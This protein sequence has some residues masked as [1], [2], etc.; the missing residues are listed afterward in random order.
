[1]IIDAHAHA[2]PRLGGPSGGEPA[3]TH[4]D[5]IQH[6]VQ[7]HVQGFRRTR[8]G[9][10]LD[11]S[12]M[13]PTGDAM[14]DMPS[15]NL[16]ATTYGRIEVTAGGEDYF[17]QWYP[18]SMQ[19]MT[20]PPELMLAHMDY[21]GVDM[22]VLQ[23]DHVYG[24]LN[25]YLA[26]C[27]RRYPS[28]FIGLAQIKEWQADQP[29]QLKRLEHAIQVLGLRGLYFAVEAFAVTGFTDHLDDAKF[30]P[31]WNLV[32]ELRIPVFW[33]LYTSQRD[34]LG[35]YLEQ[36]QRL[37][38]WAQHHPDIPCVYT[39]GI[40]TIVLRPRAERF[41]IPDEVWTCLQNPNL[42]LE[43]MLHLMAPDTE[44]PYPWAM[45]I[46]R[47][48]YDEVGP[49]RLLW[50]SDMPAAERSGTYAQSMNYIR[51]YADFMSDADKALF[52]GGNAARLFGITR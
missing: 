8:D 47:R 10:R 51:R 1:M 30:E 28:R 13:P 40:E 16:R 3:Q 7:F 9:A 31:L 44:Y 26:E 4:L 52:F 25:E 41:R 49:R 37:D 18:C 36:V 11:G 27:V 15:V 42:S 48:M 39:H 5:F 33:Y 17:L 50:G 22:A 43:V 21:L 34:R 20:A 24:T 32:R 38:R 23:H 29:A 6:H 14:A 35:G 2:F 46:L 12:P 45:D 19:D